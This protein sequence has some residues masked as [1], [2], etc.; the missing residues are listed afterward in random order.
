P[1]GAR[2]A[3]RQQL[4][5]GDGP[6]HQLLPGSAPAPAAHGFVAQPQGGGVAA[7]D[8]AEGRQGSRRSGGSAAQLPAHLGPDLQGRDPRHQGDHEEVA[9]ARH[10][11]V[12]PGAVRALRAGSHRLRGCAA[13]CRLDQRGAAEHQAARQGVQGQG[14]HQG[15]RAPGY[16]L[17]RPLLSTLL[18]A[19][20]LAVSFAARAQ[21][22]PAASSPATGERVTPLG[23]FIL[24]SFRSQSNRTLCSVGDVPVSKVEERVLH[25][26]G[27]KA[28]ETVGQDAIE[29]ALWKLFPC[30]FSPYRPE[31]I[32][33]GTKDVEGV[34]LFPHESQPYRYGALSPLQPKTVAEGVSCE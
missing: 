17:V 11:D 20:L 9:R 18:L 32:P 1:P 33:A 27:L 30:P 5:P 19:A 29:K 21:D 13:L 22:K 26:L 12:R 7:P 25:E 16:R 2:Y 34:W 24:A 4:Q 6:H 8:P 28:G 3:A 14:P 23:K 31:L 10:A 15:H